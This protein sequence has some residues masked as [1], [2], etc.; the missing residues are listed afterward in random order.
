ML[1]LLVVVE[2]AS[3]AVGAILVVV[4]VLALLGSVVCWD[5]RLG[6]KLV[7]SM[8]KGAFSPEFALADFPV[9][10]YLGFEFLLEIVL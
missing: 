1:W 3:V 5:V 2:L 8:R 9:A 7:F 10:A 6:E 4:E